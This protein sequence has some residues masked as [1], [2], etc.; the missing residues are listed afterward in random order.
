MPWQI[1]LHVCSESFKLKFKLIHHEY[2]IS[3]TPEGFYCVYPLP[4]NFKFCLDDKKPVSCRLS[5]QI[6]F[7]GD[8]PFLVSALKLS[9]EMLC[10]NWTILVL[11]PLRLVNNWNARSLFHRLATHLAI[12][13]SILHNSFVWIKWRSCTSLFSWLLLQFVKIMWNATSVLEY[14][15]TQSSF[16]SMLIIPSYSWAM[17]TLS[18]GESGW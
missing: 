12:F 6:I 15:W 16:G 9:L 10:Q 7:Q 11:S 2:R 13:H 4:Q 3:Y 1:V 18:A 17:E 14:N 5:S 8:W